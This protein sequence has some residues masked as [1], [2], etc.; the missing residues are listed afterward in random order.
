ME[1]TIRVIKQEAIPQCGS[2]EVRFSDGRPSRYFYWDNVAGRQPELLTEAQAFEKAV[3]FAE[4][5]RQRWR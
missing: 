4:A 1:K 3:A 2:I 5:E